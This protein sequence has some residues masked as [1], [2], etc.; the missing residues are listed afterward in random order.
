MK[1]QSTKKRYRDNNK[2]SLTTQYLLFDRARPLCILHHT[3]VWPQPQS[4]KD[5][6]EYRW[7]L[8][9]FMARWLWRQQLSASWCLCWE[10]CGL[11]GVFC[12]R[13]SHNKTTRHY[14]VNKILLILLYA[15][16]VASVSKSNFLDSGEYKTYSM[17]NASIKYDK[18]FENFSIIIC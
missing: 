16:C 18:G 17:H 8:G 15:K 5:S 4:H 13:M 3:V 12:V 6:T 9:S 10:L 14:H 1:Q 11:V 7:W 2:N